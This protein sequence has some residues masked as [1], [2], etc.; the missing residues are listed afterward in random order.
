M[1]RGAADYLVKP[2]RRNELR[3]LWQHVW[4]RQSVCMLFTLLS[5]SHKFYCC[6]ISKWVLFHFHFSISQPLAEILIKMRVL[7]SK[8]L[9]SLLKMMLQVIIPVVT[10]LVSRGM[11]NALRKGVMLRWVFSFC[12]SGSKCIILSRLNVLP[13]GTSKSSFAIFF[14]YLRVGVLSGHMNIL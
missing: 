5:L 3:N 8:R 6:F 2:V 7:D 11:R 4:R 14:S 13:W 1:L 10:W 9:K 12:L